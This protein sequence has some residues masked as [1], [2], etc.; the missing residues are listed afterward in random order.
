LLGT[1]NRRNFAAENRRIPMSAIVQKSAVPQPLKLSKSEAALVDGAVLWLNRSV[2]ASGVQLAVQVSDF[3]LSTFFGGNYDQFQSNDPTKPV[4]F[5]ALCQRE[6]LAISEHTL[7]RLVRIG[8][9]VGLLPQDVGEALS[10]SHHRLLLAVDDTSTRRSLA[11]QAAKQG[12]SVE[13]LA[14]AIKEKQP[15]DPKRPGRPPL[16]PMMKQLGAV[17]RAA[18]LDL[19]KFGAEFKKLSPE[20][21]AKARAEVVALAGKV[22]G[23]LDVV[24]G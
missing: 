8:R 2:H 4:T 5:A 21:Q 11:K 19:K 14:N 16:P 6:D 3:V 20:K 13:E 10:L 22:K 12:W 15:P 24:G 9:E 23:W 17:T 7:Y 1:L 18:K